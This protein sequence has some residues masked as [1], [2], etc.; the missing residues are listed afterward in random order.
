MQLV[1]QMLQKEAQNQRQIIAHHRLVFRK[2]G[3]TSK[4]EHLIGERNLAKQF[5]AE[6]EKAVYIL[7]DS[8]AKICMDGDS[9]ST[10]IEPSQLKDEPSV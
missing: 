8:S 6:L 2:Y 1:V 3:I 7:S 9:A 5:L 4:T 10:A